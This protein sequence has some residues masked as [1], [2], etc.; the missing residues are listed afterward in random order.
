MLLDQSRLGPALSDY[1]N[2]CVMVSWLLV[3]VWLVVRRRTGRQLY[4]RGGQSSERDEGRFRLPRE[5][6]GTQWSAMDQRCQ[7]P[8]SPVNAA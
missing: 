5:G 6:G 7:S 4:S 3:V 8:E 2:T 1:Y